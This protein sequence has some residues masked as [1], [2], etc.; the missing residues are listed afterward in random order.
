MG[1]CPL[2]DVSLSLQNKIEGILSEL[3][4]VETDLVILL[5]ALD[6]L[7][8]PRPYPRDLLNKFNSLYVQPEP[9]GVVL[10]IAPWNYPVQ[11][12]MLPLIGAIAAGG[13]VKL[14]VPSQ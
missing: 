13:G 5:D 12:V 6:E 1:G 4:I 8:S 2:C 3:N 11:L 10:V 9:Y 7:T 14:L